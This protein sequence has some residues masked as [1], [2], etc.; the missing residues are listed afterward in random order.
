MEFRGV[1]EQGE[2]QRREDWMAALQD[3]KALLNEGIDQ[4]H[5]FHFKIL[6][7]GTS[8]VVQWLRLRIS[9]AGRMDS[10][11]GWVT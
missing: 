4:H 9:T 7:L 2:L 10:I 5:K 11:P 6:W 1:E 3:E 8:L